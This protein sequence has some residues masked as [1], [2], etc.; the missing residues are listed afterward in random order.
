VTDSRELLAYAVLGVIG[1]LAASIF[2]H[3][4]GYLRP[5]LRNLPR[6]TFF[7]QSPVAGLCVGLIGFI[8]FPQ[9]MGPGY[10]VMDHAMH[11]Q[12]TWKLLLALAL[13]KIL[14]TTLSFSSGTP[15]GMFA[16]TLFI[17]AMLG[18]SIG[19][20]EKIFYPNLHITVGAYA[21][22]GM[23]VLFAAFL[24]V[25]LTSVF[26]VLEVSGNYSIILPV[27]LANTIAYLVSRTLQPHAIFEVFT[28]QDGLDLPSMEEQREEVVLHLEDALRP[29]SVP[30]I[31]AG[32]TLSAAA[33]AVDA[34]QAEVFLVRLPGHAWYSM[35]RAE[36]GSLAAVSA[37]ETVLANVL[38]PD[39]IPLLF[40]DLPLDSA[41]PHLARWPILPIQ[42]R[43][44]RG[45]IEG[46]VTLA[47]VLSRYQAM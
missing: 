17:G 29:L 36:L 20:F 22:V 26:M 10:E 38:K 45:T 1:G 35:T 21:L 6:W 2:S 16:P 41:L 5:R 8:G 34:K 23:G 25:P 14:A 3:A 7:V 40:P 15:G 12:Y 42:N 4:L 44:R 13:L 31:E 24:R 43:A 39:R 33:A 47:D 27:I 32:M 37:P 9:I 30:V 28:H 19:T 46:T 11:G 18:A